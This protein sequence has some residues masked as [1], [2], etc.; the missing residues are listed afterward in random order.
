MEQ[1]QINW[2]L[3]KMDALEAIEA[4]EELENHHRSEKVYNDHGKNVIDEVFSW[5]DK[6]FKRKFRMSQDSFQYLVSEVILFALKKL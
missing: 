6:V 4:V 5:S 2:F 1:P 3:D